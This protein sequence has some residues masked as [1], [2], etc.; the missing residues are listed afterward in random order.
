MTERQR[1]HPGGG[2]DRPADL[3]EAGRD[4]ARAGGIARARPRQRSDDPPAIQPGSRDQVGHG[5][6]AVDPRRCGGHRGD[7]QAGA[8][9]RQEDS[10]GHAHQA[11]DQARQRSGGRDPPLGAGAG[12]FLLGGRSGLQGPAVPQPAEEADGGRHAEAVAAG[13]DRVRQ[14][15]RDHA[16]QQ[17][18]D[19]ARGRGQVAGHRP[20][21]VHRGQ[22]EGAE[23]GGQHPQQVGP[24]GE[25]DG[26]PGDAEAAPAAGIRGGSGRPGNPGLPGGRAS[27]RAR[28]RADHGHCGLLGRRCQSCRPP[29]TT[30]HCRDDAVIGRYRLRSHP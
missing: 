4:Q 7:Q 5:Q 25:R 13:H 15:M 10:R 20:A 11:E 27:G 21:R 18:D 9:D 17:D 14:L 24:G 30:I 28:R 8:E 26:Y 12:Q 2:Q 29:I 23:P 3:A 1:G 6:Q 22:R 16:A 19:H